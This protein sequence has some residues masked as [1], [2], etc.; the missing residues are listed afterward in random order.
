MN[1][2]TLRQAADCSHTAMAQAIAPP[3]I[4][5]IL[6]AIFEPSQWNEGGCSSKTREYCE[7]KPQQVL[8]SPS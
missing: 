6:Y 1:T 2:S 4:S 8:E 3:D 5:V 7:R